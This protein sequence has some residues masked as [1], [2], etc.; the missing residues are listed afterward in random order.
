[1]DVTLTD[2]SGRVPQMPSTFDDF[3]KKAAATYTGTDPAVRHR[4]ALLQKTM[5]SAGFTIYDDEWW[6]FNDLSDPAALAGT[7]VWGWEIGAGVPP[8]IYHVIQ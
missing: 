6:H 7:P 8:A 4:L 1:M 3:S 5:T 2:L